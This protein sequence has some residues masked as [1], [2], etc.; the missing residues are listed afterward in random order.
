M[1]LLEFMIQNAAPIIRTKTIIP[2][3]FTNPLKMEETRHKIA[4]II[5]RRKITQHVVINVAK[6]VMMQKDK[7]LKDAVN[8]CDLINVDGAG[9]VLGARFLGLDIPERVAGIDLME[10]L[11]ALAADKNYS[12]YFLGA[13][14]DV[15][16]K[17]LNKYKDKYSNLQVAGY[18]DGYFDIA[19]EAGIVEEIKKS[20]ADIL[21]VGIPSPGK[22]MFLNKNLDEMGIPF[23]MGVGGSFDVVS[24]KTRRAP[25]FMQEIRLEWFYRFLQEP[26]RMWKRYLVTNS[27]YLMMLLGAKFNQG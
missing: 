6:L 7:K 24:G 15:I 10:R 11:I 18:R 13:T 22:E 3:C 14:S 4:E 23:V 17:V 26:G 8:S 25:V 27:K 21:F 1:A 12:I 5:D 9:I 2:D 16:Q 19:E 20:N